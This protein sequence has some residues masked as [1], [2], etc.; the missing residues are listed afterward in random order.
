MRSLYVLQINS[1]NSRE[2][3][4]VVKS[5]IKHWSVFYKSLVLVQKFVFI[6]ST[7]SYNIE[8]N[9]QQNKGTFCIL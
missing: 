8:I 6:I 5:E 9:L 2:E 1:H 4:K 3:K 7:K